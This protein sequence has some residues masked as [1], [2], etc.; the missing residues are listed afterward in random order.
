[1]KSLD[2]S[3]Y[4]FSEMKKEIKSKKAA[5][6]LSIG[7]VVIIVL[8]MTMLILGLALIRNIFSG[9]QDSVNIINDKVMAQII[10]LFAE[11]G[12]DIVVKL[13]A[14]KTAKIKEG[15]DPFGV[16]F[17]AQLPAGGALDGRG[18]LKYKIGFVSGG[19]NACTRV[20]AGG[21]SAFRRFFDPETAFSQFTSFGKIDGS[22]AAELI[23]ITVPKGTPECSQRIS[24][25]VYDSKSDNAFIGGDFFIVEIKKGGLF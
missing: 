7:T 8:A 19:S 6:E 22:T 18:H 12:S 23:K 14:D 4:Q 25:E 3:S 21:E 5:I 17:G 13:G 15:S 2:S 11:E 20:V 1:M 24:I 10:D 16:A 9:A